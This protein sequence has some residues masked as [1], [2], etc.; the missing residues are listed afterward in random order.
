MIDYTAKILKIDNSND[1]RVDFWISMN[2]DKTETI[3]ASLPALE[4]SKT[5]QEL[6]MWAYQQYLSRSTP[7]VSE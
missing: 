4:A 3:I 2:A 7:V 5:V 1:D 6:A